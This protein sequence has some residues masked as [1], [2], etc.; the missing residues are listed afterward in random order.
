MRVPVGIVGGAYESASLNFDA[1]RCVNMFVELGGPKSKTPVA[2]RGMPGLI[3]FATLAAAGGDGRGLHVTSGDRCFAVVGPD[4][5]EILADATV[6]TVGTLST[7]YGRVSMAENGLAPTGGNQLAIVDGQYGYIFDLGA[8]TLAII[9]DPDFPNGAKT[10]TWMDGYFIAFAA[11]T[12]QFF[13]SEGYDGTSWNALDFGVAEGSPD[14]LA[15]AIANGRDLWLPGIQTTQVFYDDGNPD[16]PFQP[17]P[18][19]FSE[20][21][22]AA[23]HSLCKMDGSVFMLGGSKEGHGIVYRSRGYSLVPIST[24]PME[25]A[26]QSYG[27]MDDAFGFTKQQAGHWFYQLTFPSANK[28]WCYDLTT[29]LWSELSYRNPVTGLEE[30]HRAAAHAFFAGKNLVLDHSNGK[31][32]ESSLT[33]YAD[34]EDPLV[35]LRTTAHLS[36]E[37]RKFEVHSFEVEM[38]TGIGLVTGQGE[39]PQ[40]TLQWSDDGGRRWS[41]SHH[42]SI[43]RIG[44]TRKR[45]IWRRQGETRGR[46]WRVQ[47]AD[48]VKR[49]ITAA[50]AEIEVLDS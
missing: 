6:T 33:A 22:L 30:R 44:E 24:Q 21:G 14:N 4:L 3:L 8:N 11:G 1:Q 31:M 25:E 46:C 49:F 7:S 37:G 50:Y 35:S 19:A 23:T 45:V 10:I 48:P 39:D 29:G 42:R 15:G 38:E 40:I 47:I 36:Y 9:A 13:I 20:V 32:Y 27:A 43:G 17:I 26:L 41:N 12:G 16:F 18:G 34:D 28:T 2:L 5:L